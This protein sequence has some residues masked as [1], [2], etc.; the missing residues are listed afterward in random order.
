[1]TIWH[2]V[3]QEQATR[4][5]DSG[6]WKG[7]TDKEKVMLQLF[8]ERT[9]MPFNEFQTALENELNHSVLPHSFFYGL[10]AVR[11]EWMEKYG[12]SLCEVQASCVV[13]CTEV[14]SGL[15]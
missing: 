2:E 6:I 13:M 14:E 12:L 8:T 5:W 9:C 3:S 7:W 1:M 10:E 4:I 11:K 15:A